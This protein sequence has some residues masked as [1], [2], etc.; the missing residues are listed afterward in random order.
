M[1]PIHSHLAK[2][3]LSPN[4]LR[5]ASRKGWYLLWS[6]LLLVAGFSRASEYEAQ[7]NQ[8][9]AVQTNLQSWSGDFTQTRA[10]KVLNQPLISA[11]K[12]WVRRG[13]F[14]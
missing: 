9:F 10:L 12:V 8:W 2:A 14:R 5:K 3:R 13:E 1:V 7:F 6:L 11:G 4:K